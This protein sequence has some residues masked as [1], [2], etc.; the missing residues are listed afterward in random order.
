M[1]FSQFWNWLHFH[2]EIKYVFQPPPPKMDGLENLKKIKQCNLIGF[3]SFIHSSLKE[4]K[5]GAYC[6]ASCL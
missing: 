5:K 3:C 6:K 1:G 2:K 4:K